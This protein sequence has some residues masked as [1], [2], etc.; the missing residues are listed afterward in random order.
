MKYL[1][2]S[3]FLL[4]TSLSF[5]SQ[6]ISD[7]FNK[8]IQITWLGIDFAQ[9]KIIG[10]WAHF[11]GAGNQGVGDI[12][13][14]YFPAWNNLILSESSKYNLKSMI[15]QD[16]IYIDIGMVMDRNAEVSMRQLESYNP[17]NYSTEDIQ[18]FV[19][20]YVLERKTGIGMVFIS[21]YMSKYTND[22]VFHFVMLDLE[23]RQILIHQACKVEPFGF[24]IRNYWAGSI[25]DLIEIIRDV[26]YPK[27]RRL[28]GG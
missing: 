5:Y 26:H 2:T 16:D 28:H 23:T 1:I 18:N 6:S 14:K 19:S 9:T 4:F 15:R 25:L 22:A 17:P 12:R 10:E 24:G 21:E 3:L 13:D 20:S 7:L 8:D 11:G 27:W